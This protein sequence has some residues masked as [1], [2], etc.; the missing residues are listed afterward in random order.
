MPVKPSAPAERLR[1]APMSVYQAA[2]AAA[3]E[4]LCFSSPWSMAMLTEELTNPDAVYL[5]AMLDDRLLG[6]AGVQLV[7][8]EGYITN[9]CVHPDF[10]R[11]GVA[12]TLMESLLRGAK[13]RELAFLTLEVRPSNGAARALYTRF[14]FKEAGRR[15]DYYENPMEDALIMTLHFKKDKEHA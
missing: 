13:A 12:A 15:K 11:M 14:G 3:L 4:K 2:E 7:L 5:A 6:Y 10:R 1:V 9:I 8:D